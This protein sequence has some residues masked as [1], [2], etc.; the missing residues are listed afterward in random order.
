MENS[1]KN[2]EQIVKKILQDDNNLENNN[3][4]ENQNI[5]GSNLKNKLEKQGLNEVGEYI[6]DRKLNKDPEEMQH[7]KEVCA[8]FF[9][10][11]VKIYLIKSE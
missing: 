2:N 4:I 1:E 10:Y 8:A 3:N 6:G 5:T 9:N 11:Q 7:L